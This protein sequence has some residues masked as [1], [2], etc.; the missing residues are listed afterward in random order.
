MTEL[1]DPLS[2]DRIEHR[3]QLIVALH[4]SDYWQVLVT[5]PCE[6]V[7]KRDVAFAGP[8]RRMFDDFKDDVARAEKAEIPLIRGRDQASSLPLP[9]GI[10]QVVA[11]AARIRHD[12]K[13]WPDDVRRECP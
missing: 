6:E 9:T 8:A 7:L 4:D 1:L 2:L 13:R 10:Q 5:P 11:K 3:H 12:E